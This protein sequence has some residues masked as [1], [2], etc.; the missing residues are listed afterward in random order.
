M[1]DHSALFGHPVDH[2]KSPLIHGWFAAAT[3]EDLDYR[4]IDV[5]PESP[6]AFADAVTAFISGGGSGVNVTAPLTQR[7]PSPWLAGRAGRRDWPVPPMRCAS[8]AAR[9]TPRTSTAPTCGAT[10]R[11]TSDN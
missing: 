7:G 8:G 3:G 9:F 10:S 2:S 5:P 6:T 4:T 11:S 1:T